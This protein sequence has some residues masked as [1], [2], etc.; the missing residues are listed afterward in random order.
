[1]AWAGYN[2]EGAIAFWQRMDARENA[3]AAPEF[4]STHPSNNTRIANIQRE[5]PEARKYYKPR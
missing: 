5:L 1:M 3:A 2:P 4:L